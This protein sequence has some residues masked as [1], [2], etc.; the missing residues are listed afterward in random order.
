MTIP[1][2]ITNSDWW[3]IQDVSAACIYLTAKSSSHPLSPRSILNVFAYLVTPSSPIRQQTA[4]S[5]NRDSDPDPQ[6]YYLSEGT[7]QTQKTTLLQTESIILR[8]ISFTTQAIT[9]HHLA[10]TYL[11]ALGV[12]PQPPT[13]ASSALAKRTLAHLNTALLSPQLLY[14]T[15]QPNALAV[16]ACYLAAREVGTRLS[17]EAWWEVFDVDRETLGFL[18]VA[19]LSCEEW[20]R[21]EG[22]KWRDGGCPLTLGELNDEIGKESGY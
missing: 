12:L 11:Q 14:L 8:A 4:R 17:T 15:H 18:S 7:Y 2:T 6:S 10:L 19:L 3:D 13:P 5:S 21:M 20:V 22:E 9:P 1:S 16:S